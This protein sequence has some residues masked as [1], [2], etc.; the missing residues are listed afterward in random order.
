MEVFCRRVYVV[1]K[2]NGCVLDKIFDLE[3]LGYWS[4]YG[5][6]GSKRYVCCCGCE[7]FMLFGMGN[8]GY[9]LFL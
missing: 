1:L 5:V 2:C 9:F 8:V 3:V 6:D 4:F 7:I